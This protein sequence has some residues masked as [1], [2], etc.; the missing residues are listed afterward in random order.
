MEGDVRFGNLEMGEFEGI[1]RREKKGREEYVDKLM[2][3]GEFSVRGRK[4]M[5]MREERDEGIMKV[6]NVVGKG[7]VW[8]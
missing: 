1:D 8:M 6:V 4:E 7:E 3:D 5:Y 2:V